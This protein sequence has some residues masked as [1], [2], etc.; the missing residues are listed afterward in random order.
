MM[1]IALSWVSVKGLAPEEILS[2]LELAQTDEERSYP[3]EGIVAH[4]L[5]QQ[6]FLVAARGSEHRILAA[7]SMA[8]LSIGCQALSCDVEEH[9]GYAACALWRDG[10]QLWAVTYDSDDDP[11]SVFYKGEVPGRLHELLATVEAM[12]SEHFEG[13]FH[14]DIPLILAKEYGGFRHDDDDAMFDAIPFAALKDLRG[15]TSWWKALWR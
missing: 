2:R 8:R 13:H 9:V 1:G 12:D 15:K 5:P 14:M 6:A 3:F 7:D 10:R 11:E 4:P